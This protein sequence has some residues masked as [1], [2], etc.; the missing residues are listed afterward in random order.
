MKLTM[1]GQQ[2]F[3]REYGGKQLCVQVVPLGLSELRRI[4]GEAPV[5]DI[6]PSI[7]EMN[8]GGTV[9]VGREGRR[10]T[11]EVDKIDSRVKIGDKVFVSYM[12]EKD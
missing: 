4:L 6:F 7:G 10:V 1:I 2:P 12:G 11:I 9:S 8:F 3:K 5:G